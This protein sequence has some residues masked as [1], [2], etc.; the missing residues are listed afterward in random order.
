[1]WSDQVEGP[2]RILWKDSNDTPVM[3]VLLAAEPGQKKKETQGTPSAGRTGNGSHINKSD[4]CSEVVTVQLCQEQLLKP[5]CG[6]LTDSMEVLPLSVNPTVYLECKI[7]MV[8]DLNTLWNNK[9][10]QTT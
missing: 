5:Q 8:H 7:T 2:S 9:I 3:L 4:V 6:W 1:M 10:K